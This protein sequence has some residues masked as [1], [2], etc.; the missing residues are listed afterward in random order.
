MG[1]G[2]DVPLGTPVAGRGDDAVDQ[3]VGFFV[4]TLVLRT[5]TGGKPHLPR[6]PRPGPRHRPDRLR[7]PGPAVR[8]PGGR[9]LPDQV[10]LPQPAVPGAA[11]PGHHPAGRPGRALRH[12]PRRAAAERHHRGRQAGPRPGDRRA[13][14]R[15]RRPRRAGG[16]GRV[17]ARTSSTRA[18]SRCWWSGSCGSWTRWSR[19]RPGAS[20]T[21]TCSAPGNGSGS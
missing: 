20:A 18:P 1:A 3:V 13:P 6:T 17:P 8:A 21:S 19:T 7:P 5:D 15:R 16:R 14:R 4:N 10:A 9:P 11:E 2:E 12:R